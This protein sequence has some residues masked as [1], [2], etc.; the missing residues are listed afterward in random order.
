MSKEKKPIMRLVDLGKVTIR[1]DYGRQNGKREFVEDIEKALNAL[2]TVEAI[3][4]EWIQSKIDM[5]EHNMDSDLPASAML[6]QLH[7][8]ASL[9]RLVAEWRIEQWKEE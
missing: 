4:I 7:E 3:P 8:L 2:P 5:L 9:K 1:I 6:A